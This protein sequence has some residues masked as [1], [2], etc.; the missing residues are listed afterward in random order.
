MSAATQTPPDLVHRQQEAIEASAWGE[1][2]RFVQPY[3][4]CFWVY[5]G[6]MAYGVVQLWQHEDIGL[7]FYGPALGA[8]VAVTAIYGAL[9]FAWF[10]HIDRWERQP[11][12][13][14]LTAFFWGGIAATFGLAVAVNNAMLSIYPKL[15]GQDWAD[16]W[17]PGLTAPITEETSKAAGFILLLALAP[18]LV[19][20]VNDGLVLGAFIGL[21]FQLFENVTYGQLGAAFNFSTAPIGGALQVLGIRSATGFI[22]HPAFSALFCAG[23]VYVVGTRV[24]ERRVGRGLALMAAAMVFH[25]C[26]DA[27]SSLGAGFGPA[28]GLLVMLV[29]GVSALLVLWFAF[30]LAAPKEHQFVRDIL[31]PEVASGVL[32]QSELD[33]ITNRKARRQFVRAGHGRRERRH[34][35]GLLRAA[36]DLCQGLSAAKGSSSAEVEHARAEI[37]RLRTT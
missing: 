26:W 5:L 11:L 14:V 16:S 13:L 10:R 2:F 4:P 9:W 35:K 8:A 21:G 34:R 25:G 23:I 36:M 33:A 3:N 15:F 20:T 7:G 12:G 28:G 37:L 31:A 29:A 6:I 22:S 17:A 19:R 30:R 32:E 1:R 18:R 24:Q 27:A